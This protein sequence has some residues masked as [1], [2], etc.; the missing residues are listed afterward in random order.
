M[1]S[2]VKAFIVLWIACLGTCGFLD[3]TPARGEGNLLT[4]DESISLALANNWSI[5]GKQE[6]VDQARYAKEQARAGFYPKLSTSYGYT[7]LDD[8]ARSNAIPLGGGLAIPSYDL[9]TQDNY[10]WKTSVTQPL[11][12]GFALTSSYELAK[13]GIDLGEVELELERLALALKV[14]EVYF[15]ILKADKVLDVATQAVGSLQSNVKVARS[16]YDVGMIP[17]NDLLKAEVELANAQHDLVKARNAALL[18]R[19][20]FSN[21]L[22]RPVNDPV[23]V[24]D[25]LHYRPETGDF[26]GY[27]KKAL[28]NRPEVKAVDLSILQSE[29]KIRLAKSKYY[30]EASLVYDYI[31]EGDHPDVSGSAFHDSESWQV[32]AVATWTFWEWGKTNNAVKESESIRRELDHTRSTLIDNIALDVKRAVLD[33]EI[34][35]KNIPT[36]EK[37]VE[38]AEENLRVSEERYKAQVTTITEVLDAQTLLTQARTNYYG[39]LYDHNLAKARLLRAMGEY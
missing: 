14:K 2:S 21:V 29:Q 22:S 13:L 8:V 11:F 23:E 36:T 26:D 34:A 24:E 6:R 30:P 15:G 19:S 12:T 9:N 5:K 27:L 31:K 37:A 1:R 7:R 18:A 20:L 35:A 28:E 25:I 4:L 38:Q 3:A 32:M 33:I 10:Q 16:Y 17:I 39:A